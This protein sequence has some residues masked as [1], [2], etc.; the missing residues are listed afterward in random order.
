MEN[1]IGTYTT[2]LPAG[3]YYV[4]ATYL[5]DENYNAN[6]TQ[7]SFTVTDVSKENTPISLDV[8][9]VENSAIFTVNVDKGATGLVK[10]EVND[11]IG[12]VLY[13]D[14][15]NGEVVISG[16]LEHKQT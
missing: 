12:T 1:G 3:S 13:A 2:T 10:F 14:V 4:Q 9:V 8:E 11:E 16:L 15:K 6:S 5:G 7:T